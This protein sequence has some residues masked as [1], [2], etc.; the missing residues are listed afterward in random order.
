MIMSILL[1]VHPLLGIVLVNK[2]PQ[3]QILDKQS[4]ARLRRITWGC[5]FYVVCAKQE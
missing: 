3:R 1:H 4:V 5:V 2:F